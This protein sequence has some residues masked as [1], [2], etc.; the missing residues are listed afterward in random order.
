MRLSANGIYG[1]AERSSIKIDIRYLAYVSHIC[2][3]HSWAYATIELTLQCTFR[4]ADFNVTIR[5]IV[6]HGTIPI[7]GHRINDHTV[8]RW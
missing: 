1:G 6:R 3:K 2:A 8:I 5:A 4:I 7:A